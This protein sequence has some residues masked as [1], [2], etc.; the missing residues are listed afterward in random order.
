MYLHRWMPFLLT[1]KREQNDNHKPALRV[2][3]KICDWCMSSLEMKRFI[4]LKAK[5]KFEQTEKL[6]ID[7]VEVEIKEN[8]HIKLVL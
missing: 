7:H 1:K 5:P 4:F 3:H 2:F 6:S 8:K